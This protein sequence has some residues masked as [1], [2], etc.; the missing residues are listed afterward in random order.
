MF[1]SDLYSHLP[2]REARRARRNAMML[3]L[4]E[5]GWSQRAVADV[6][7]VCP[8]TIA[9]IAAQGPAAIERPN[10]RPEAIPEGPRLPSWLAKL[11]ARRP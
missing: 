6:L 1:T 5:T 3:Q 9:R 2:P 10:F 8:A 7:N 4:L 11:S